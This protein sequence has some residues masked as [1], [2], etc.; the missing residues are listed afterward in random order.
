MVIKSIQSI[1]YPRKVTIT[2]SIFQ[3]IDLITNINILS[4]FVL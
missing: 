2:N 3:T 1:N 4:K